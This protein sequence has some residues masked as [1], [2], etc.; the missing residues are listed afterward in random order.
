MTGSLFAQTKPAADQAGCVD[1]KFLPKL[2]ECRI[3]NCEKKESEEHDLTV[4]EDDKGEALSTTVEGTSRA[5]MYECKEGTTPASLVEQA[6]SALKESGFEIP[7]KFAESE[8]SLTARKGDFW[9]TVDAASRY[10]TLTEITAAPPDFENM[11]DSDAIAEKLDHYGHVPLYG[12]QFLPGRADLAPASVT[13]MH[14]VIV[15]LQDHPD[16]RLRIEGH[17]DNTG[18]K[19]G[20]QTLSLKRAQAVVTWL[21]Q[22]GVKRGRLDE[23]QGIGDTRPVGDN[24]TEAGRQKNR[25]IE[26]VKIVAPAAADPQD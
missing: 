1:S 20:N 13:I 21:T 11:T 16:W 18:S 14:E 17:T 12:I 23:P 2:L 4:G 8:A 26:L 19:Q 22:N 24:A 3:D 10:Y 7:Y 5:L 15:L 6:A 9:I 25:R